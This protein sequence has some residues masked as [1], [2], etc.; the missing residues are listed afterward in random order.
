MH[1]I[2]VAFRSRTFAGHFLLLAASANAHVTRV[3]II[4]RTD[5]ADGRAFGW[6]ERTRKLWAALF[7]GESGK[8]AQQAYRRSR[9]SA[10]Q[11]PRRSGI[12]ADLI[13]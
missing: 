8:P 3:E 5:I 2:A 13:S 9:Q 7:R 12:S 1:P 6:L 11:R 10:A 4:S